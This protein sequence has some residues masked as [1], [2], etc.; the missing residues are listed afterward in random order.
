MND[1]TDLIVHLMEHSIR[2]GD[3]T[4]KS[5]RKSSWFCDA[6]Q[7]A[8]RADG[9]LLVAEAA[10]AEIAALEE[11][12]GPISAIGGLTAGADP[13]AF[14]IAAVAAT[15]GRDLRSFS[16]RK[17]SKDHGVQGRLAGALRPGDRVIVCEDTVTRGT[18]PLEAAS[19]VRELGAEPVAILPIVDRGG[20]CGAAAA[21]AGLAFLPLVSAPDLGFP[22]EGP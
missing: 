17:E 5:G 15:R 8:C 6:K 2:T 11:E 18:S 22:Y 20:T 3:F 16:I 7:T 19:V 12:S 9:I 14:G 1:R 4:L 10:L 21:E 13:V